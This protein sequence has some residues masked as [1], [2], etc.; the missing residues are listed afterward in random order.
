VGADAV[1]E[2][3]EDRPQ[4]Q[5]GLEVA[6]A[7][8]G[9]EQVLVAQGGVFGADVRVGGGDE[10]LAS[11][12]SSALILARSMTNRPLPDSWWLTGRRLADQG[13]D[14]VVLSVVTPV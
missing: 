10:V 11:S 13:C 2:P 9:F 7:A 14:V 4:Q 5:A 6:E 3:V 12:R 1:L 8:L